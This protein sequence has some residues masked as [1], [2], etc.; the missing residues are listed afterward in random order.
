VANSYQTSS[1][2]TASP[3][4]PY[5]AE[6]RICRL[7]LTKGLMDPRDSRHQSFGEMLLLL[8]MDWFKGK[9]TGKHHI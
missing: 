2:D 5:H 1:A 8:S 6:E 4:R 9:F 7:V 3:Y